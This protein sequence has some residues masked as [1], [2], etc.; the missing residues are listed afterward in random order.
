MYL[1]LRSVIHIYIC[2]CILRVSLYIAD[3]DIHYTSEL[4]YISISSC[5]SSLIPLYITICDFW[6]LLHISLCITD[7]YNVVYIDVTV[8]SYSSSLSKLLCS[9]PVNSKFAL[10]IIIAKSCDLARYFKRK[11]VYLPEPVSWYLMYQFLHSALRF[12]SRGFGSEP[13]ENFGWPV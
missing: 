9:I 2:R 4:I 10:R 12:F 13:T 8:C 1:H 7:G 11:N 5:I 3:M 6:L